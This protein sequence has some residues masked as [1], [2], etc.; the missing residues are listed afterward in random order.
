[1]VKLEQGE[2]VTTRVTDLVNLKTW[3]QKCTE[4]RPGGEVGSKLTEQIMLN[5]LFNEPTTLYQL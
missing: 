3:S 2:L 4:A 5:P 1:M